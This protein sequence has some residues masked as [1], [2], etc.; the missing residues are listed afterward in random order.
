[1]ALGPA[2]SA[3]P[4]ASAAGPARVRTAARHDAGMA[5]SR[6][7]PPRLEIGIDCADPVALA[8]FWLAALGYDNA[9]GDGAPY[10][11]LLPPDR[12]H[13]VV[14]LQ[15]VD[16]AKIGKNRMHLDLYDRE[17]AALAERLRALGAVEVDQPVYVD[18]SWAF[19]VLADPAGNEFCVCA[20][21]S[22][23]AQPEDYR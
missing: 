3:N 16:D 17:P 8:P 20:E 11:A 18:G 14:F 6:K 23:D 10:V 5:A 1:M 7:R 21:D 13:P 15:R 9:E 22:G 2:V 19:Q 4:P 12:E